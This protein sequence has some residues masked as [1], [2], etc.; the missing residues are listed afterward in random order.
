MW[1]ERRSHVLNNPCVR[2][3]KGRTLLYW[4]CDGPWK[5]PQTCG[6]DLEHWCG[7]TVWRGNILRGLILYDELSH[8]EEFERIGSLLPSPIWSPKAWKQG[9]RRTSVPSNTLGADFCLVSGLIFASLVLW[10][11]WQSLLACCPVSTWLCLLCRPLDEQ[12]IYIGFTVCCSMTFPSITT[13]PNTATLWPLRRPILI[14]VQGWNYFIKGKSGQNG[15]FQSC[16]TSITIKTDVLHKI[17]EIAIYSIQFI[18]H[19]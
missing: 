6:G 19:K 14:T 15:N 13:F 3:V 16:V 1:S 18:Y 11:C 17:N 4:Y 12:I 2:C 9:V 7:W 5:S 10:G 8:R